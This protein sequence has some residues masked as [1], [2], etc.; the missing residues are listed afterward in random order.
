MPKARATKKLRAILAG[1]LNGHWRTRRSVLGMAVR[2]AVRFALK[3]NKI[4][5]CEFDQKSLYVEGAK[6]LRLTEARLK[7][8]LTEL[9]GAARPWS[10]DQKLCA[11]AGWLALAN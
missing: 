4:P 7:Q 1:K 5:S 3:A 2:D 6:A 11:L 8:R 9:K 10:Q